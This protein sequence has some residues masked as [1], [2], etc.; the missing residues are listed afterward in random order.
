M[1]QGAYRTWFERSILGDLGH[2]LNK[3]SRTLRVIWRSW[4]TLSGSQ[5]K[6]A[7]TWAKDRP[8]EGVIYKK[9]DIHNVL[10][11]AYRLPAM[12]LEEPAVVAGLHITKEVL[13]LIKV[14]TEAADVELL[15]LLIPTQEA[16]YAEAVG[17]LYGHLNP[18]YAKLVQMEI[19]IKNE[20]VTLCNEN[21]I[22][23]VDALPR[24]TEALNQ[25]ENIYPSHLDGHPLPKGYFVVATSVNDILNTLDCLK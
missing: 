22:Q 1:E 23:Y 9:N 11:P 6:S 14:E 2:E 5:F 24:L 10:Q 18:S 17:T 12:D 19:G 15:I 13:R 16:V 20:L 8:D 3:R 25:G 4:L 7:E 21:G